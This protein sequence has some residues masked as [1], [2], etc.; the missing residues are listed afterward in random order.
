MAAPANFGVDSRKF[1]QVKG[2]IDIIYI[3]SLT[4]T[5]VSAKVKYLM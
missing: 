5:K 3:V 1:Y 4:Y 2:F